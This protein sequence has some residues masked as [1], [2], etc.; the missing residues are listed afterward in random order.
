MEEDKMRQNDS[1]HDDCR[2]SVRIR[3][4]LE[5]ECP[6]NRGASRR[7]PRRVGQSRLVLANRGTRQQKEARQQNEGCQLI[8]NGDL[9]QQKTN[10][11]DSSI[12][13][14]LVLR[15][16]GRTGWLISLLAERAAGD[17]T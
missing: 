15:A 3:R 12:M 9:S 1:F 13:K 6:A 8:P 11:Q 10:E 17:V 5:S 7:R 4:R 14:G 16:K 2:G